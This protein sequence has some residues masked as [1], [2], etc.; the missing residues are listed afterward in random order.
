MC[1][2][3]EVKLNYYLLIP[4]LRSPQKEDFAVCHLVIEGFEQV[5]FLENIVGDAL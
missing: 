5:Q 4:C 1:Q 2:E 3:L